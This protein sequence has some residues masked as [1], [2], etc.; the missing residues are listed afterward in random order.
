MGNKV[1]FSLAVLN[2]F[3]YIIKGNLVLILNIIL[4]VFLNSHSVL[5]LVLRGN[6]RQKFS[7]FNFKG[8]VGKTTIAI[9]L[10][11]GLAKADFKVLLIDLDSQNNYS[12]FLGISKNE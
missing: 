2:I 10:S 7:S 8:D 6:S 3:F 11:H 5:I 1:F 12:L 9:Q 4:K